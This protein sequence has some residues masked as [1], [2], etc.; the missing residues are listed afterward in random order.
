MTSTFA[1]FLRFDFDADSLEGVGF[2][3]RGEPVCIL[4]RPDVVEK[5]LSDPPGGSHVSLHWELGVGDTSGERSALGWY[6]FNRFL[7][8]SAAFC[9]S[10]RVLHASLSSGRFFRIRFRLDVDT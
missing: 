1:A 3:E 2:E 10:D 9:C 4:L 5:L 6:Y 7:C 8:S